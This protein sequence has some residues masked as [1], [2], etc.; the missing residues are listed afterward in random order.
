MPLAVARMFFSQALSAAR[1]ADARGLR[2]GN[3]TRHA[4]G[5]D[6]SRMNVSSC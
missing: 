5:A 1:R 3:E 2:A 4:N 6:V